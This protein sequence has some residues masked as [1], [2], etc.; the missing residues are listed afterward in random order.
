MFFNRRLFFSLFFFFSGIL[1]IA[2]PFESDFSMLKSEGN[3][4]EDFHRLI[5]H[6]QKNM[7]MIY[8]RELFLSG[9]ILY[10]TPINQYINTIIEQLLKDY[11]DLK[12][13]IRC[14]IIR[15][16]D[17]NA[18]STSSGMLFV[19]LGLIAQITN[20]S[21][22]AFI[23]AHEIAHYAEKHSYEKREEY[24]MEKDK[25]AKDRRLSYLHYHTRSREIELE[26]DRI[27]F[28]RYFAASPYSYA[29]LDGVF[30][31]LQYHYLPFDEAPFYIQSFETEHY[32]FP[33]NYK[34]TSFNPI[35]A[36]E[37]YIDTL[38]THP[39]IKKR[40]ENM[41]Q[42]V[43]QVDND[44]RVLFL[45]SEELFN[46][47]RK[48]A[49]FECINILLTHHKYADALYNIYYLKQQYPNS[50]FL[51]IGM[52]FSLYGLAKHKNQHNLSNILP[53]YNQAEGE[54]QQTYYLLHRI[55]RNEL[56]VLAFRHLWGVH[57][58]NPENQFIYDLCGDIIC[59][60]VTIHKL[61]LSDFSDY[62]MGINPENIVEELSTIDTIKTDN[63]YDRIRRNIQMQKV[64]PSSKFSTVNY[65]LVDLKQDQAFLKLFNKVLADKEDEAILSMVKNN[66]KVIKI[67]SVL[68]LNASYYQ[69]VR[70]KKNKKT[71]KNHMNKQKQI[72]RIDKTIDYTLKDLK[73]A[74]KQ[75]TIPYLANLTTEEYNT[76]CRLQ[77]F[78]ID[79]FSAETTNMM[80]Y[81]CLHIQDIIKES[82]FDKMVLLVIHKQESSF[83]N[84]NKIYSLVIVPP[85]CPV[86]LPAGILRFALPRSTTS[87]YFY[88][89]DLKNGK[90]LYYNS[91]RTE[92]DCHKAYS[93]AYIYDM[94]NIIKGRKK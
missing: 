88:T 31:V 84:F 49:R 43:L 12:E 42:K 89:V 28:E 46:E 51:T 7:D 19:N 75:F 37:D 4:P 47:I 41:A 90:T 34:L 3:I 1:L 79:Y 10:G 85:I 38:S 48:M 6:D 71:E 44:G 24:K 70:D 67:D 18:Y 50:K 8:L 64:K 21:E 76:F 83:V 25:K 14:Y 60:I 68:V 16:S 58:A 39:N 81:Q 20:E 86:M 54:I 62:P 82:G 94:F 92:S 29:V 36:R 40:R 73:F 66:E 56:S 26:A 77:Q 27:A 53:A 2:Q 52:A 15:S 23:L 63:K 69:S 11:P 78:R 13:Q 80:L 32:Q 55:R 17:V 57:L 61:K 91:Q 74:Y 72:N 30:D 87:L 65:M 33:D 35:R 9:T 5:N 45:Q 93:N 59:D 22:L